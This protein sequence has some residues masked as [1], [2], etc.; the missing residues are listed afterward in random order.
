M[1]KKNDKKHL[2]DKDNVV[3]GVSKQC[4]LFKKSSRE[5]FREIIFQLHWKK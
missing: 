4:L 5:I 1:K 2:I 3:P